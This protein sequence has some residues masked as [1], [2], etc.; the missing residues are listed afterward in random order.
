MNRVL[1]DYDI[2]VQDTAK[3][4]VAVKKIAGQNYCL[5]VKVTRN[6]N[7]ILRTT[8]HLTRQNDIKR[9]QNKGT[10]LK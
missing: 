10:R 3:S 7:E 6:G 9:L 8:F 4:V 5:A 1:G 2:L